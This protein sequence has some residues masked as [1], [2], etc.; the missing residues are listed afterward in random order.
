M[1]IGP[2]Q[3]LVDALAD[4]LQR[5]VTV[6][7]HTLGLVAYSKNYGDADAARVWSLL[8]RR[9]RPDDVYYAELRTAVHPTRVA[10]NLELELYA[11]L[12]V[13]IRDHDM[14]LGFIWLIDRHHTLTEAQIADTVET[15]G[16]LGAMLYQRLVVSDSQDSFAEYLLDQLLSTDL[17]RRAAASA[18]ITARGLIEN[19]A[20]VGVVRAVVGGAIADAAVV[21]AAVQRACRQLPPRM[22]MTRT[23]ARSTTVLLARGSDVSKAVDMF[24]D[25][26]RAALTPA[27]PSVRIGVSGIGQNLAHAATAARQA[28][29]AMSV[30]PGDRAVARWD[31]LGPYRLIGQ[32]PTD[33]VSNELIP[34][35]VFRLLRSNDAGELITTAEMFLDRAGDKQDAAKLLG[36]H[37]STMYYRLDRIESITELDLSDGGDRLLL[38][39]A[40]KLWRCGPSLDS[41]D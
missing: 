1:T 28:D 31:E 14:L 26:V 18:E 40:I 23:T 29:I 32:L 24:A 7:D 22:V 12:C 33:L 3:A 27:V 17:D 15:A 4:R 30:A 10:E 39:L 16:A 13:P 41:S 36:I 20:Y 9:S 37:R 35:G 5:S 25:T 38:H 11:R 6:E 8:N 19:D 2:H 34:Q 21:P